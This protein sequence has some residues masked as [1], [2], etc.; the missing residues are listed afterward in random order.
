MTGLRVST[1]GMQQSYQRFRDPGISKQ[2]ENSK[3]AANTIDGPA[4]VSH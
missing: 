2:S 3:Q 1:P 4:G